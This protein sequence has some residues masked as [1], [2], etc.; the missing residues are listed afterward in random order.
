[1]T[2]FRIGLT[3][4]IGSGKSTAADLFAERGIEIIDADRL[5]HEL[6]A[7]GGMA[8]SPIRD[9]FGPGFIDATGALDRE[10][11]RDRIFS[12]A[13]AKST[14][15]SILHPMIRAETDRRAARA[16]SP[17]VILMIPLLVETG[18]PHAR[19]DRVVV[20]DCPEATQIERVMARSGL[21][22]DAVGAI[23][24]AQASR[25]ERLS[26]ADDVIDNGGSPADLQPQVDAL[27]ARYVALAPEH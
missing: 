8:I 12:D 4:G 23:M 6:T 21:S 24:A 25:T 2:P 26:H 1:M 27:H 9:A 15:E 16:T 20:V 19:C 11:M 22:R 7:P 17:Y 10:R 5:A 13:S 14:L 18:A 3:G